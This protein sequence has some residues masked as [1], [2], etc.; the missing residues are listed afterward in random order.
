MYYV[1]INERIGKK[2]SLHLMFMKIAMNYDFFLSLLEKFFI[3]YELI[4]IDLI[5]SIYPR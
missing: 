1:M 5:L 3:E 4:L 2:F